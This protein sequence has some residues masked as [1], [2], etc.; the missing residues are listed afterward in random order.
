MASLDQENDIPRRVANVTPDMTA[1]TAQARVVVEAVNDSISELKQDVREI[2]GYRFTDLVLHISALAAGFVL[3]AGMMIAAYFKL[4][5][6]ISALSTKS[7]RIET[8][9]EDLLAR[10]PPVPSPPPRR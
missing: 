2:K 3:L 9:L 6:K 7:T 10:I 4:E 8:K 5:D 1:A